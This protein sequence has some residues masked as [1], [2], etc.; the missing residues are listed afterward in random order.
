VVFFFRCCSFREP[1]LPFLFA[2]LL[3][4]SLP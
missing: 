2:S 1:V 3:F 4:A